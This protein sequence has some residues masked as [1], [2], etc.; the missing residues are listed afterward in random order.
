MREYLGLM[1]RILTEGTHRQDRTGVGTIGLFGEQLKFDLSEGF[2]LV[3]TKRMFIRGIVEELVWFLDGNTDRRY[4]S[5]RNVNIWNE[6]KSP[7]EDLEDFDMGP[8][9]GANWRRWES[10]SGKRPVLISIKNPPPR[11]PAPVP[12]FD[13]LQPDTN[14]PFAGSV[15]KSKSGGSYT[16]ISKQGQSNGNSTYLVQFDG[17]GWSTIATRPNIRS[18]QV[19]DRWSPTVAGVG[20]LGSHVE[21]SYVSKKAYELWSNMIRRCYDKSHP[22]FHL[23]GGNGV[24]V[25]PDWLVFSLFYDSLINLP[26]FRS[27]CEPGS[28]FDLD[29]DY[30]GSNCYSFETCIFLPSSENKLYAN[31][32]PVL[33]DGRAFVC[34]SD[35]ADYLGIDRRRISDHLNG[36]R[37]IDIAS[38]SHF[39]PPN[40]SVLRYERVIDQIANVCTSLVENP[41]SRRHLVSAWNPPFISDMA[42]PPCHV[43]FQFNVRP[44]KSNP[45]RNILDCHMYQRSADYFL[46]VPFNIASY[47][48]LTHYIANLTGYSPGNLILS[49]GDVHIYSNHVEQVRLQLSREPLPLPKLIL[50]GSSLSWDNVEL[51]DY[52]HHPAIKASIAV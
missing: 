17:T 1:D 10:Y 7:N 2:P 21:S 12:V 40:G 19:K 34:G 4:L 23:Y 46:G 13:Q 49:F 33:V 48:I 15:F 9:Y 25:S 41:F 31:A 26:G 50:H 27:W 6:W 28:D 36:K 51:V 18:G 52:Q 29:K 32:K 47:A 38:V 43:M 45:D 35:A 37:T 3:T 30:Y 39:I 22:Q 42:L 44:D 8:I 5:D 24:Y 20:M 16:V 14:D 11:G